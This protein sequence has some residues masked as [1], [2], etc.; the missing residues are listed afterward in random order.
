MGGWGKLDG[1][2]M[3]GGEGQRLAGGI[4]AVGV[5]TCL[6]ED[7]EV[8][9][10]EEGRTM[11]QAGVE[12]ERSEICEGGLGSKAWLEGMEESGNTTGK[13]VGKKGGVGAKIVEEAVE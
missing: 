12:V 5:E 1:L 4:G 3:K 9:V 7:L 6:D 13:G 8:G 2:E 11:V 10:V